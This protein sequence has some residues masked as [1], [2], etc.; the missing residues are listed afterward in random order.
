MEREGA[1]QNLGMWP[2]RGVLVFCAMILAAGYG[3]AVLRGPLAPGEV[4]V[5]AAAA[6]EEPVTP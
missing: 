2:A 3:G 4:R 5:T 6:P 1:S